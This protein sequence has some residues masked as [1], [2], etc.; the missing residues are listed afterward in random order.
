MIDL[1]AIVLDFCVKLITDNN[2]YSKEQVDII[3]YGLE[4]IY[5]TITKMVII[6]LVSF[7]LGIF[8]DVII[9]LITYN[10]IRSQAFGLHA[11][12]SSYCLIS[13]LISFIGGGFICKY[14]VIS[15]LFKIIG[16]IVCVI[17]L[18]LYAPADTY[19]RPLINVRKRRRFKYLSVFL[20]IVYTVL[21]IFVS[22]FLVTNYLFIGM[23][24]SVGMILPITYKIF[25]LPYNNYKNYDY[26]V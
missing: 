21:I 22:D 6:F 5:L 2:N 12:K 20:G 8:K 13:S 9:L 19:K 25:N 14:Y 17:F 11:S 15:K 10:I 7:F 16:S 26:G 1:K 3:R 24:L 23:I 18:F 4:S